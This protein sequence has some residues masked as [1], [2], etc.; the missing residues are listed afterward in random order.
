MNTILEI[1]TVQSGAFKVMVEALKDLLTDTSI[2]FDAETGMKICAMDAS[3]IVLVHLHLEASKFESF[4]CKD[5]ICI[6]TNVMQLFK[7]LRSL[8]NNDCLTLFMEEG[9]MNHLGIKI[10]NTQ[11]GQKTLFRLNLLDLDNSKISIDPVE[12][13][14]TI[15]MP[16]NDFQ[17]ICRDMNNLAEFV[18]IKNIQN[19]LIFQCQGDFCVQETIMTDS[20]SASHSIQ[21]RTPDSDEIVQGVFSL[22]YLVLFSKCT[23]LCNTVQLFL[24]ND[25]PLII[26][27]QVASL[28]EIKLA[29]A[30]QSDT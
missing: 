5:H 16:S 24:R 18:E 13:S 30:P 11:K 28:G 4:Y 20:E 7:L 12:F 26:V 21:P 23:N 25:Y 27:Y 6:G 8:N 19:Q 2:E 22:K 9:D 14:S 3:R 1:R 10:E 29:L 17:K 15:T